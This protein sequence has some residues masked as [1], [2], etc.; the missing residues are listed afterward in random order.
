MEYNTCKLCINK[1]ISR[2]CKTENWN[3]ELA[4]GKVILCFSTVGS[5]SS[6]EAGF[7]VYTT[8][9]SALI[10]VAPLNQQ[11]PEVDIIP[12]IHIDV[13]RGTKLYHYLVLSKKPPVVQIWASRTVI[14][15][16]PAP[17]VA[18]F[19]SRGPSSLSPDF[20]KPDIT[21][22]G[23]N[24]LAAWPPN[25]SPTSFNIDGRSVNWNFLSGTSMSCPHVSGVVALLKSAHPHWSPAAIRSA[26]MTTAYT[27][28]NTGDSVLFGGITKTGDPFDIGAGHVDPLNAIDPGLIYDMK[29]SDYIHFL[30]NIGY[31]ENKIKIIAG[32]K[33]F[34]SCRKGSAST[35]NENLNYPS[36]T[37]P[38]LRSTMTI[39]RTV[40]NV[41]KMKTAVYFAKIVKPDGVE[42]IVCPRILVFSWFNTEVSYYVT[43][44]PKKK[45]RGRYDFGEI[46][47]SDG[48]HSVRSPL[49][50]LVNTL[51][52]DITTVRND[53]SIDYSII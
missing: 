4:T 10:F 19:S 17:S 47:W 15:K 22:P 3:K 25:I 5:V 36:I 16:S 49:I 1:L 48:P 8:N 46:I 23:I 38:N 24:I 13:I 44:I 18:L 6:G 20:L 40:T 26:L 34:V 27:H 42:V 31:S 14:K 11:V 51:G 28:D 39:K 21:A 43:F 52:S 29:T 30:C 37:I 53:S 45:S 35:S 9:A 32:T 33:T 50:V 12:N 7:A 2:I 41:G